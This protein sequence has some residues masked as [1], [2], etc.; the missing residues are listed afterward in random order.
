[1]CN[2]TAVVPGAARIESP[3]P[4]IRVGEFGLEMVTYSGENDLV[5]KTGEVTKIRYRFV[6]NKARYVD[7]RDI[8]FLLDEYFT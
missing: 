7:K 5:E 8:P 2:C 3:A 4:G 1:M 6:R